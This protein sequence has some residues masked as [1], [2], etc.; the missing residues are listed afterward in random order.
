MHS[1]HV[2]IATTFQHLK[3]QNVL[4][5]LSTICWVWPKKKRCTKHNSVL[6]D[7]HFLSVYMFQWVFVWRG[8]EEIKSQ[9]NIVRLKRNIDIDNCQRCLMRNASR[10]YSR[11]LHLTLQMETPQLSLHSSCHCTNF[12]TQNRYQNASKCKLGN[13]TSTRMIPQT[14]D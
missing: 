1:E 3:T 2:L 11:D 12:C 14:S 10:E 4:Y 5:Y 7:N 13:C 6:G 9:M 8:R